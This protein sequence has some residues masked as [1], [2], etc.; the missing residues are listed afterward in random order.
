MTTYQRVLAASPTLR[1]LLEPDANAESPLEQDEPFRLVSWAPDVRGTVPTPDA[2]P[3]S[4]AAR[5][6]KGHPGGL[7]WP[8][9]AYRHGAIALRIANTRFDTGFPDPRWDVGF[10]GFCTITAEAL[11]Y[12][13]RGDTA[14]ARAY[15]ENALRTLTQWLNGDCWGYRIERRDAPGAPWVLVDD[16][17]GFYGSN[18]QNNTMSWYW[19][20]DVQQLVAAHSRPA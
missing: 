16:Y 20:D 3:A 14:Q 9:W 13:W 4:W 2:E 10:V 5:W 15:V 12:E 19:P 11:D 17:W 6:R 8:V 18:W 1:V 7:L